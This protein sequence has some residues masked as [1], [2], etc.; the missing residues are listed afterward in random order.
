M[1]THSPALENLPAD[2]Q[3][4]STNQ[5]TPPT[6]TSDFTYDA[7]ATGNF[8]TYGGS[9]LP[10]FL[11][12]PIAEVAAAY[13]EARN[14]P[15]FLSQYRELLQTYVGRPTLLYQAENLTEYVRSQTKTGHGARIFLKREDLNHSG[16]HKINHC[17]G[18]ALL[19][20]RMG[21]RKLI[22]ETGAGQHGVALATAAALLGLECEIHMGR[23]DVEKQHAN[24]MRMK[25][26]GAQVV[27]VDAG[28]KSLKEAVDSAFA[29]YAENYHE[30]F[31]AIGSVVGPHPY[32]TMVRDFQKIIGEEARQ[33]HLKMENRL[34]DAIVACVGGGSN[35]MG[36]FNAFLADPVDIYGV[37]PAGKGLETKEHAA[38]LTLGTDGVLHGMRTLVLQDGDEP[39]AVHSIAS[40]LDYPGVG[41]QHA[42]LAAAGRVNYASVTDAETLTAFQDLCRLE[43][44]IPALESAHA[45]AFGM[46]LAASLEKTQTII[47]NLSGRGD[48]D[49]EYVGQV[50]GI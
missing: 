12:A 6:Q 27:I 36:L 13:E 28:G 38:T 5:T 9:Y 42:H 29:K 39:A 31:F 45:I 43:G 30:M 11:V 2:N 18:E 19:A 46:K 32:P 4:S 41:P 1:N 22:A 10:D 20:K 25:L 17:L 26:L 47:V 24:V 21:K 34:P 48:K 23:I 49:V 8:G 3:L 44:I 15:A 16:A 35:A 37:E 50:L 7:D 14:D 33:Q 40:G